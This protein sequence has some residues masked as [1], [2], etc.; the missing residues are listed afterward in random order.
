M[1]AIVVGALSPDVI[2]VIPSAG[3]LDAGAAKAIEDA[4]SEATKLAKTRVIR[5][6][7]ISAQLVI[8]ICCCEGLC[9]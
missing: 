1:N 3:S 4:A 2:S 5:V 7:I 8:A 6:P 9:K